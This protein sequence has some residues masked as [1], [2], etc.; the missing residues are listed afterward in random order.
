V[1]LH[2]GDELTRDML[3]AEVLA[4]TAAATPAAQ[5]RA[6]TERRELAEALEAAGGDP[7]EAGRR[8]GVSRATVYRRMKKYGLAR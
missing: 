5:A 1:V 4:G 7:E 8:L 2:D 6:G 3:P